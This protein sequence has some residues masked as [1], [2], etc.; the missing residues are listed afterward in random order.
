MKGHVDHRQLS[1]PV[2]LIEKKDQKFTGFTIIY[3]KAWFIT[4]GRLPI[5]SQFVSGFVF[6][7][8][9][10]RYEYLGECGKPRFRSPVIEVLEAMLLPSLFSKVQQY[11]SYFGPDFI[12]QNKLTVDEYRAAVI[13]CLSVYVRGAA[14]AG[15]KNSLQKSDGFLDII[16]SIERFRYNGG[17]RD[18]DGHIE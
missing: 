2:F 11:F 10:N 13:D 3:S 18:E 1:Y 15:L 17:V 8:S 16:R 6:D 12:L 9:G 4:L 5:Q 7:S 14:L